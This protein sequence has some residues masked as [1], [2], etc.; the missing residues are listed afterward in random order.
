MLYTLS[1]IY[2]YPIKSLGGIRLE[3]SHVELRGLQHDRRFMLIDN[4]NKF[5]T[6]RTYP[7]MTLLKTKIDDNILIVYNS[8]NN[9][10]IKINL[11][12]LKQIKKFNNYEKIDVV[13]WEDKVKALKVS[14]EADEFFSDT[15]AV[16]CSLVF[17]PDDEERIVDPNK[18]YVKDKH[19]VGFADAYPFLIIGEESLRDLNERLIEKVPMNRFRPNFVFKGG[20]PFDEDK[21]KSFLIGEIIFYPVKPCARCVITTINQDTAEKSNEPLKTLATYRTFNNKVLFG[22][23]LVHKGKGEI[24][25]NSKI[26]VLEWK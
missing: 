12:E 21:W 17:M 9:Q 22:Q 5:M 25:V 1:D 16:N 26:K 6:Q 8:L 13:I 11:K 14:K 3:K 19:L 10:S 23:N 2:I 20:S 4:E 15:L 24:S 18:K 7:Q